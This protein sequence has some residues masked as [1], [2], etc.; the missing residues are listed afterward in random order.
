M[1]K[2]LTSATR[3]APT[4]VNDASNLPVA[5]AAGRKEELRTGLKRVDA[6]NLYVPL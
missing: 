2:F 5:T 1:Q 4:P 6:S 3:P